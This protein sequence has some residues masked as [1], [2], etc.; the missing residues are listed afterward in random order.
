MSFYASLYLSGLAMYALV[1][2]IGRREGWPRLPWW[3]LAAASTYVL[4]RYHLTDVFTRSVLAVGLLL[5]PIFKRRR[6]SENG[7]ETTIE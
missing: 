5:W 7:K 6:E 2:V 3:A 4:I 1:Y